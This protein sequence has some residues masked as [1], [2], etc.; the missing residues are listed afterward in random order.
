MPSWQGVCCCS[1]TTGAM[2]DY[3]L[4]LVPH[5]RG[6]VSKHARHSCTVP[7]MKILLFE[8]TAGPVSDSRCH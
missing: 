1:N 4:Q 3:G 6:C 7:L 2:F 8:G 5:H